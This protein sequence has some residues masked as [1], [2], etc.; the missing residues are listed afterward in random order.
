MKVK[1]IHS[2][3]EFDWIN[4]EYKLINDLNNLLPSD[5]YGTLPYKVYDKIF[6]VKK[7]PYSRW[8]DPCNFSTKMI[9]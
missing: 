4:D 3:F 9:C 2:F 1:Y 6:K 7:I 5:Q 8:Q